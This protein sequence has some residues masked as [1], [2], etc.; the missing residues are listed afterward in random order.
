MAP[1]KA[2]SGPER[3]ARSIFRS[4]RFFASAAGACSRAD[5]KAAVQSP[6]RRW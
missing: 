2:G 6:I 5:G 3:W 4:R 1:A